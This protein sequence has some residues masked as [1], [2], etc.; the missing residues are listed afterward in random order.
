[1]EGMGAGRSGE[2]RW[3]EKG[4]GGCCREER[5]AEKGICYVKAFWVMYSRIL[6]SLLNA[7]IEF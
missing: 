6:V 3:R 7:K 2:V 1:M 4:R 5:E